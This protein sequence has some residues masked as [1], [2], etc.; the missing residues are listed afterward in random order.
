MTKLLRAFLVLIALVIMTPVAMA[1]TVYKIS[2]GDTLQL[3]VLEDP[4][5]NR[6]LLV[7][8]DG[9]ITVPQGGTVHAAGS[10]V[11]EVQAAVATALTQN[12]AKTPTVT[13]AVGQLAPRLAATGATS[14][15]TIAVYVMGEVTKPGRIDV[16]P[17]TTMLQFLAQSGG[18]TS[19]AATKRLQLRRTDAAGRE[20]VYPFN[21]EALL[22]GGQA[23]VIYL[24]KGDVIIVPQRK[25]FE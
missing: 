16:E 2:P 13:L 18:L 20:Q 9:N 1:Q 14:R 3:E 24:Q 22:S 5:L 21:Y 8:P 15:A 19:F 4:S 10:T 12:F 17:G 7:L 25:L 11:A 23:P 6:S